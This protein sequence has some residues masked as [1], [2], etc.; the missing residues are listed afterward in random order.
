MDT[1]DSFIPSENDQCSSEMH[2]SEFAQGGAEGYSSN[3]DTFGQ[4]L[5]RRG[6][7]TAAG[8]FTAYTHVAG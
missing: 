5:T 8:A 1:R 2:A 6:F 7:V 4:K 3:K